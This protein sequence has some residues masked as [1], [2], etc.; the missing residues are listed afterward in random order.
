MIAEGLVPKD[1]VVAL[2]DAR[3]DDVL[4]ILR[5]T[6]DP[7]SLTH[8]NVAYLASRGTLASVIKLAHKLGS[9][10]VP[11]LVALSTDRSDVSHMPVLADVAAQLG[12]ADMLHKC[13]EMIMTAAQKVPPSMSSV[14]YFIKQLNIDNPTAEAALLGLLAKNTLITGSM[15][16]TLLDRHFPKEGIVLV[17]EWNG[18][19]VCSNWVRGNG[20]GYQITVNKVKRTP[21][22]DECCIN[23]VIKATPDVPTRA[24]V[25]TV[26]LIDP[27]NVAA[28]PVKR[29]TCDFSTGRDVSLWLATKR[30]LD[31]CVDVNITSVFTCVLH[32]V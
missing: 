14:V 21:T 3:L 20:I 9:R 18:H 24:Y 7:E 25:A 32:P 27:H 15:C 31:R 2:D 13:F 10:I 11:K 17:V 12:N 19:Q 30:D 23:I 28:S 6:Y 29:V 26:R 16:A 4:V 8:D 5:F 22:D 1:G